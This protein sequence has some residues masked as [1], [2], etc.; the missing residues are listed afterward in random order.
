MIRIRQI[1]VSYKKDNIEEIKK[2]ISKKINIKEKEI[3][4]MKISKKSLDARFKPN[5]FYIYEVDI[6]TNKVVVAIDPK[7][8]RPTEVDLL[9]GDYSKAKSKLQSRPLLMVEYS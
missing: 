8:F 1:K 7:Y 3:L 2:Q 5:L 6:E 4:D 9:L